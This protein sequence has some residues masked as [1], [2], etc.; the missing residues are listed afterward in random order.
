VADV[1]TG[2]DT[3]AAAIAVKAVLAEAEVAGV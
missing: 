3:E 1:L 2:H